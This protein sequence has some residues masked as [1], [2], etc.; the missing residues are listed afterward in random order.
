MT[1]SERPSL[2]SVL[3]SA[4]LLVIRLGFGG[5]ML[6][7]HGWGKL[8]SFGNLFDRFPDPLGL[9]PGV[10]LILVIFA[11]VVCSVLVMVGLFTRVALIPLII[12]MIVV[13]FWVHPGDPW[14][15]TELPLLYLIA[16]SALLVAGSGYYSIDRIRRNRKR[17]SKAARQLG[18][19]EGAAGPGTS[20]AASSTTDFDMPTYDPT[21]T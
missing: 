15:K 5:M 6:Y 7:A 17:K 11:E 14:A 8:T 4:A 12:D 13:V 10:S 19:D 20:G 9:G 21:S 3:Q 2:E 16:F 18:S 1:H